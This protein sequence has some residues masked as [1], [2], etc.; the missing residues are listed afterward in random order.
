[1]TTVP[2]TAAFRQNFRALRYR[3]FRLF[4][5]G[6]LVS[7]VGTWM[8]SVAQG[9]LMHRL[10][11]SALMLG[12]L[13]FAQFLPVLLFSLWAGVIIDRVDKR[14]LIIA[15]QALALLQAALLATV[16]SLG[17]VAP[18]MLI[19]LALVFGM[20][21]AFDLPARQSFII[22]MVGKEDLPNAIALNSAAFNSARIIGPMVAGLLLA[23]Y[24]EAVCF[25]GNAVSYL[26]VIVSLWRIDLPPR[27][28]AER[29]FDLSTFR[30]GLD[31]A[32]GV[33]A[34]RSLLILLGF[35][36]GLGFQYMVLLPV[37]AREI[38]LTDAKGYGF[39]VSAFGLGSLLAA[40]RMMR[41]HDRWQLRRN[42]LVGLGTAGLGMLG[43]AWSRHFTLTLAMGFAAGFGLILYVISTNTLIQLTTEDRFRGR[44][45]SF[46]TFMFLG[47]APLGALVAGEIAQV[48]GAPVATTVSAAVLLAGAFW[49]YYRLR[50]LAAREAIREVG[51][52]HPEAGAAEKVD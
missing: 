32:L 50:V 20:V 4:W 39:L 30:E 44:V 49:V 22:E 47:T 45:M 1:M 48:A 5:S 3:N 7:V 8:Q 36:T 13:G 35:T 26:A 37:Y 34:I 24:G 21:N 23:A 19:G 14:R 9:W 38:L 15:T 16:V 17:V 33:R 11:G 46:Y 27:A 18:W 10:T 29:R 41:R 2:A 42:L 28:P 43:F 51:S 31:Y 12:L 52:R 40:G 6:Q 25:W